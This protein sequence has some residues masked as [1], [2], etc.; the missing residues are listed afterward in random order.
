VLYLDNVLGRFNIAHATSS[1][2]RFN[3]SPREGHLKAA[4]IILACL[5]IF[6]KGRLI[7]DS[8]FANHST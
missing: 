6:P 7:V 1:M 4:K 8:K 3:I 5:K 2:R